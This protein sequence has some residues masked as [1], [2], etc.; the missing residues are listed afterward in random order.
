MNPLFHVITNYMIKVTVALLSLFI[1]IILT[2][3]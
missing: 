1:D 2:V 3:V